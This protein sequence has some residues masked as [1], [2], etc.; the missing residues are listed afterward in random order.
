MIAVSGLG[1]C[2]RLTKSVSLSVSKLTTSNSHAEFN[3]SG[4]AS[5]AHA[6][7]GTSAVWTVLPVCEYRFTSLWD[8]LWGDKLLLG[9]N[10]T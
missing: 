7:G 9:R 6:A 5:E 4:T 3:I 1:K 8:P 10:L 2:L